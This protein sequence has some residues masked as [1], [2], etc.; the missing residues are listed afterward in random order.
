[1]NELQLYLP[2][3]TPADGFMR[4]LAGDGFPHHGNIVPGGGNP[5]GYEDLK[6]FEDLEFLKAVADG[7]EAA[8]TFADALAAAEVEAAMARSWDSGTWEDVTS[9]RID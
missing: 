6:L 3:E 7:R 5:I 1:M 4:V 9:L 8:V 2:E